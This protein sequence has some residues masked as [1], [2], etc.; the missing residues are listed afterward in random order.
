MMSPYSRGICRLSK[1]HAEE[2]DVCVFVNLC[3]A[4]SEC[5]EGGGV[6]CQVIVCEIMP[7][8][9]SLMFHICVCIVRCS[10]LDA[11][12]VETAG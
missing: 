12:C 8:S 1:V 5:E 9:T 10:F 2:V 3:M 11:G 6:F 4:L 7:S